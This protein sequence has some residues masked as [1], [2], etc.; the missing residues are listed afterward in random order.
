M[1]CRFFAIQE[2][3]SVSVGAVRGYL[4]TSHRSRLIAMRLKPCMN[5]S[6]IAS[7]FVPQ[8]PT[9][10]YSPIPSS[11]PL[12]DIEMCGVSAIV[13]MSVDQ[14]GA[15]YQAGAEFFPDQEVERLRIA[16]DLHAKRDDGSI[17][18]KDLPNIL[19]TLFIV[20]A[21]RSECKKCLMLGSDA[22]VGVPIFE[23]CVRSH[24]EH[25]YIGTCNEAS[26][27]EH[28]LL[29]TNIEERVFC[30]S[31][32]HQYLWARRPFQATP[33]RKEARSSLPWIQ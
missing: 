15:V 31:I 8:S 5:R 24:E 27:K 21:G 25:S 17:M 26:S 20:S 11:N 16:F 1:Y 14:L 30:P 22:T 19:K 12:V 13:S 23:R 18:S 10:T 28:P 32:P 3:L 7:L 29:R 9:A 4:R 2:C 33:K 6:A